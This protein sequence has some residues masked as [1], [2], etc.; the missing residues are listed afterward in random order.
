MSY[1]A[2][3]AMAFAED[4]HAG[5]LRKFTG[6]PYITHLAEVAAIVATVERDYPHGAEMI[7]AAWLHDYIEDIDPANGGAIITAN[8]GHMVG[9]GV[10]A[11]TNP[12]LPVS[13]EEKVAETIKRLIAAP[14]WVQTIKC[15]DIISNARDIAILD[16]KFAS[17]YLPE[18]QRMLDALVKAH[19]WI[20]DRA[21]RVVGNAAVSLRPG[22]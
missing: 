18:K 8:F 19:P 13:R 17:V 14:G 11:L 7:A 10:F 15:A 21:L 22:A 6:S 2:H 16:K 4:A 5:H 20:R 12:S 9:D 3:K 1:I